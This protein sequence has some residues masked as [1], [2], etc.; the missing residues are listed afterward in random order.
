ME[1]AH[2]RDDRLAG[3][4]VGENFE[5]WIFLGEP[6][7]RDAH[8]LLVLLRLWLD[9][10]RY[11]RI[12]ERGWLEQDWKIFVAERVARGDVLDAN[13]RRDVSR[14]AGVDIFA[15]VRLNLNQTANPLALVRARVV[16][17]VALA[18]FSGIDAEENQFPNEWVAPQ[19]ESEG[20]ELPL[21]VSRRFHLLV[22]VR[23]HPHRGRNVERT[24]QI[25]DH[26]VDE[27]LHSLVLERRTSHHRHELIGDRL[28]AD[29]GLQHL[30][31][32]RLLFQ[33]GFGHLVVNIGDCLD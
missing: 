14:E 9:R 3:I 15:F 7:K 32:N 17:V 30:R 18:Q 6:L 27:V 31:R 19:F 23:L 20:T 29:A 4:F 28:A 1:F 13:N 12:R 16:N 11:N 24:R 10:H 2:A 22:G 25:I 8:L 33:D 26:G 5:S 21:V